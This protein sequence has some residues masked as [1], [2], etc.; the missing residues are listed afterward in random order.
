MNEEGMNDKRKEKKEKRKK[1]FIFFVLPLLFC[2]CSDIRGKLSVMEGNFRYSQGM[3]NEA[4]LSY[5]RALDYKEAVPYAD[6]GLG[7]VYFAMGED[8]AALDRFARASE[9]LETLPPSANRE[10][11]YRTH[12]NTGVVLFCGQ[13]FNGAADSFRDALRVDGGKIEAKRNLELSLESLA[14]QNIQGD[15]GED[16]ENESRAILFEYLQQR[17]I[18]LYRSQE[19]IQELNEEENMTGRD[20]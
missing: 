9:V 7:S 11:R 20:Y 2:G 19:W 5:L 14:R 18:N 13:D 12:F 17:E 6:Y 4:I 10:L 8:K 16:N 1:I 15:E 3:Y